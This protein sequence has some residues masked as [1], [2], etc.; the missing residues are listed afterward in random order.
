MLEQRLPSRRGT[1][2]SVEQAAS[3]Y[4]NSRRRA[5]EVT[6]ALPSSCPVLRTVLER[7]CGMA[8]PSIVAAH[9][10]GPRTARLSATVLLA[11]RAL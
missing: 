2:G 8:Q 7:D 11:G 10:R 1:A 4:W 9:P 6:P 3:N 5:G